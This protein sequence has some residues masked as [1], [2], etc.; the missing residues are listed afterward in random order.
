MTRLCKLRLEP[1]LA[2]APIEAP[3]F[4]VVALIAVEQFIVVERPFDGQP[5][6]AAQRLWAAVTTEAAIVIRT[7][8]IAVA[9]PTTVV[10]AT[11][12]VEFTAAAQS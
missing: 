6:L 9:A 11:T 8:N 2:A 1:S 3:Q 7:I 4:G 12:V 10:A 5:L